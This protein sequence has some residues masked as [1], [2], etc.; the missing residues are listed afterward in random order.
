NVLNAYRLATRRGRAAAQRLQ[1]RGRRGE[2]AVPGAR[3]YGRSSLDP[4]RP[5]TGWIFGSATSRS[6]SRTRRKRF[7]MPCATPRFPC[8][9]AWSPTTLAPGVVLMG[10]GSHNSV[11]VEF[12]D[13]VTVIEGPLSNQR[14][15]AVV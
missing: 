14:T 7:P 11:A 8:N 10:G 2:D 15:N 6:T 9:T 3:P 5:I 1:G 4:R 12:K 13:Y